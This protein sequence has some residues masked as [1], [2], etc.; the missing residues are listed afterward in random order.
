M[1][2]GIMDR[3]LSSKGHN[4]SCPKSVAISCSVGACERHAARPFR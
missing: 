2:G 4:L 1:L 3:N